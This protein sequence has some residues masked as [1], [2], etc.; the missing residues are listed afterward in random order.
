V[1]TDER[2]GRVRGLSNRYAR[3]VREWRAEVQEAPGH[4]AHIIQPSQ[5]DAQLSGT[6]LARDDEAAPKG[7]THRERDV[8]DLVGRGNDGRPEVFAAVVVPDDV[9]I[10]RRL[11]RDRD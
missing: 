9:I 6:R 2:E 1:P 10:V 3:E 8:I 5:V 4:V 11:L 7:F